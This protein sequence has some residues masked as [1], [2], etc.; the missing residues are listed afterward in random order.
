[1][2]IKLPLIFFVKYFVS[3]TAEIPMVGGRGKMR[4]AD[5]FDHTGAYLAALLDENKPLDPRAR[6][7]ECSMISNKYLNK[8]DTNF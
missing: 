8:L 6:L 4:T 7:P 2:S 3:S 5:F 1:L